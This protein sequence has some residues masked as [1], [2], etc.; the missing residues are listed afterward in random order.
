MRRTVTINER[1]LHSIISES[2]RRILRE[3]IYDYPDGID[4]LIFLAENDGECYR[5]Y[6]SIVE[7]LKRKKE[8]GV[9]LSPEILANSSVMKRYQQFV[10]RKFRNEQ[11]SLT[12]QTPGM[13]REYMAEMMVDRINGGEY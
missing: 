3:G 9:D 7:M 6:W 2:V 10:F 1:M 8:K 11:P 12:R 13:F 4:H 5:I